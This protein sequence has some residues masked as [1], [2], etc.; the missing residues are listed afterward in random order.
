MA[1]YRL[2][3]TKAA[4]LKAA[5]AAKGKRDY[6][7]DTKERS[8]VLAVTDKGSKSFYLYKRIDGRPERVLL[9][10]FP[11][12]SVENART[13]A[14]KA[15]GKIAHG[16]NPQNENRAIRTEIKFGE[17]F[18]EYM[19]RYSKIHKR[20]WIY[21]EREINKHLSHWFNKRIS[22]IKRNEIEKLHHRMGN[23]NGIY[24]ANRILERIKVIFNKA[25]EWGWQGENPANGIKKYRE[26]S[27]DRFLHPDEMPRFFEAL[28]LEENEG[29]RDFFMLSLLTGA[30]KSNTLAMR[31]EEINFDRAIWRIEETKNSEPQ[32]V[33]LSPQAVEIL[34]DRKL[35]S[36]SEWVFP[37]KGKAG[38]LADPK[39]AW[40]RVLQRADIQDLRIHD[41]RRTLGSWQAAA[42]ANSYIIGKSLGHKSQQ[43]TAVYARLNLDPVRA[44]V[45]QATE[46]MMKFKDTSDG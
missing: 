21:D 12:I 18:S 9:G 3:F 14:A 40:Q 22:T 27:R 36:I 17:L 43:S 20:S 5:P 2:N 37:G 30:R 19:E 28:A 25:I 32:T 35:K 15:K 31:W 16:A 44:S 41:L 26:K 29:A 34:K 42:G 1:S 11:D 46:A 13:L 6:H 4:L 39:K 23:E 33:T 7:Y 10:R 45:N 8:L 24:A 38:H